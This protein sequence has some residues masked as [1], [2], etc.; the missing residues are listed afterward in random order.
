MSAG[1][2]SSELSTHQMAPSGVVPHSSSTNE[3]FF[4]SSILLGK[5]GEHCPE[6]REAQFHH[7]QTNSVGNR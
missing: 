2:S 7:Y 6:C 3:E 1:V 5:D 4:V